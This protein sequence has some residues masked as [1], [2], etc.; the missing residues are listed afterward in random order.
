M[1]N[2]VSYWIELILLCV[3]VHFY[4]N[5]MQLALV[6]VKKE[7]FIHL[8]HFQYNQIQTHSI[9]TH[10]HT[11]STHL[12][13]INYK[14]AVSC[15]IVSPLPSPLPPANF[16]FCALMWAFVVALYVI[17]NFEN[18]SKLPNKKKGSEQHMKKYKP[19]FPR[20]PFASPNLL[21]FSLFHSPFFYISVNGNCNKSALTTNVFV[22]WTTRAESEIIKSNSSEPKTP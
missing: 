13:F 4:Q 6:S 20:P 5:S 12:K 7:A 9:T 21:R 11:P 8:R 19:F 14:R 10:T 16:Q 22:H 15:S 1:L 17:N 2:S 18:W 3:C